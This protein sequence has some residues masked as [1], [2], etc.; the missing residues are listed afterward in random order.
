M[1]FLEGGTQQSSSVRSSAGWKDVSGRIV[2]DL[3]GNCI[4]DTAS[5][6]LAET[7]AGADILARKLKAEPNQGAEAGGA[8]AELSPYSSAFGLR[9]VV[10]FELFVFLIRTI[11][12]MARPWLQLIQRSFRRR[13]PS[14]NHGTTSRRA[15]KGR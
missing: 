4:P 14:G 11:V 12:M 15:G 3:E 6:T 5:S 10:C 8:N 7:R 9:G 13:G 1:A 2:V